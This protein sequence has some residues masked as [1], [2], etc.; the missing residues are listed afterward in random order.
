[1]VFFYP[2]QKIYYLLSLCEGK[3]P[4]ISFGHCDN[5]RRTEEHCLPKSLSS[6]HEPQLSLY[7]NQKCIVS[8]IGLKIQHFL[9]GRLKYKTEYVN[10]AV[11]YC[12]TDVYEVVLCNLRGIPD[13]NA[14]ALYTVLSEISYHNKSMNYI[15][16]VAVSGPFRKM[17]KPKETV[18]RRQ[19]SVCPR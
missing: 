15:L 11:Q 7:C 4:G 8:I 5:N 9:H 1:M 18:N 14:V 3:L 10:E 6:F 2:H 16:S 19:V 17:Q 13:S 12:R